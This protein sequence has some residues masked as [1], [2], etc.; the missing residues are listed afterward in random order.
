MPDLPISLYT[1]SSLKTQKDT[2]LIDVSEDDGLGG[3]DTRKQI[4]G[5]FKNV[6]AESI[7]FDCSTGQEGTTS[8]LWNCAGKTTIPYRVLIIITASGKSMDGT[9]IQIGSTS[10][11]SDILAPFTFVNAFL[12]ATY[13]LPLSGIK[14]P[15]L[16]DS[17]TYF[18]TLVTGGGTA[19]SCDILL[20]AYQRDV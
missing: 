2:D 7:A 12:D 13:V 15:M 14:P 6:M 16:S 9:V 3:F 1:A 10:G 5:N 11:A 17:D 8:M 18:L 4:A 20:E 19:V